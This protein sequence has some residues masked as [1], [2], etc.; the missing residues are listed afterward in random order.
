MTEADAGTVARLWAAIWNGVAKALGE[1]LRDYDEVAFERMAARYRYLLGTDPSGSYVAVDGGEV[2]GLAVSHVRGSTFMLANLGV[3]PL[4]QD[5][6]LGRRL[7]AAVLDHGANADRGLICS[8][9]DP[10]ALVRYLRAG[11]RAMPAMEAVGRPGGAA[12]PSSLRRSGASQADLAT[13]HEIDL[14]VRGLARPGDVA[15][16]VAS[17]AQLF[18]DDAGAYALATDTEVVTVCA[19]DFALARRT[20]AALLSGSAAGRCC[21]ARWLTA[22]TPWAF[23]AA[24]EVRAGLKGHGAVMLQGSWPVVQPWLPSGVFG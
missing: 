22:A 4:R 11:F 14:Q 9:P 21:T 20:L 10:R 13:V 23:E 7:L 17:G 19:R 12:A 3:A 8:S 16:M 5:R 18:V 15:A 24:A 2:V 6:G 1:E